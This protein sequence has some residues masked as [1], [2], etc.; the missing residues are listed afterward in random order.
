MITNLTLFYKYDYPYWDR[1]TD[2]DLIFRLTPFH[3]FV[4]LNEINTEWNN[5]KFKVFIDNNGFGKINIFDKDLAMLF[6]LKF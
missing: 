5:S 6:K 4:F 2:D 3:I 1:L